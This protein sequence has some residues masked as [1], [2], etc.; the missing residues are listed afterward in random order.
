MQKDS[1]SAYNLVTFDSVKLSAS[2]RKFASLPLYNM[3]AVTP[4]L[5]DGY[6]S[7]QFQTF[8]WEE[9]KL[10]HCLRTHDIGYRDNV[11]FGFQSEVLRIPGD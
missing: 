4:I 10:Y 3:Q 9:G 5:Q 6:T 1:G 2:H 11:H 7:P 8:S